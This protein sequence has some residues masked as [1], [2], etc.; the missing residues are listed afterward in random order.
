MTSACSPVKFPTNLYE[1][2]EETF[3][4]YEER[5]AGAASVVPVMGDMS[6]ASLECVARVAVADNNSY[7]NNSYAN[8]LISLLKK[9]H[10]WPMMKVKKFKGRSDIVLLHNTYIRNN[11]DNFKELYEQCRSIV[12][13]FSLNCNNNIVVTYA[14][15]IPERINY[16]TYISTLVGSDAK[17]S[18]DTDKVYEAYDGTIIT[19]YHYKDEWYFGTSSCPDANSSKFSHPTKTHGNMF[20]EIL[21]KYFR[22]HLTAEDTALTAEELS[23]KLR[24]LFVQHL[25]PAMAYEFIIVHHENRHIVDYTGLLGEN[26]MEMFHI[27]TKHRCS[28]AENDIMSSIIPSLLEVGVKYPL[29][30]NNIQEAYAHIN[31]MPYSYGL[32]VKKMVASGGSGSSGGK[33]KLYKISTDAINYREETD[34]CHP[35]IWMNILSVY[36]KNKTEYTIKDYIANYHPYI[37]LPVDNNGQ[38]IDPTYLVH[39]IISTIKDSLYSYYKATTVY[40]PNYNRYKMN[41]EMDKQF[42]PIIQYHLAQ[43]RNLQVNTYKTKMITMGNVYHYICQCNDI[44]NIKTLIQFFAS[45]PINEM[46]PRTSMCFAIMTSLIS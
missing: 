32:I 1:L 42:P 13:D 33:V 23:A 27:N 39:T 5:Y 17:A 6:E 14:N 26:Y 19:V 35:N 46:S 9:Y 21:Y 11:V 24:G 3:K 45:N 4:L 16:N 40:Y 28:L 38:K 15:S 2:I 30:F 36:M 43:L 41:K 12:L 44:N 22:H 7:A 31:T 18:S 25:D 20:D 10:L 34:P 8:C 29:P 37:N